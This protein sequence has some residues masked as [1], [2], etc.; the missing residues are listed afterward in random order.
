MG[1]LDWSRRNCGT[2]DRVHIQFDSV[3]VMRDET[4]AIA[5]L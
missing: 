4:V 2:D 5:H 3:R 1:A